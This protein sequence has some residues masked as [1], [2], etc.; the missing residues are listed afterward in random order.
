M[1]IKEQKITIRQLT[2]GYVDNQEAGVKA[3]GGKLD[4]RPP[5]QREFVYNDKEREAVIDTVSNHYPLNVMYWAVRED[6]TYEIIDGQQRTISICQYVNGDFAY[7]FN[8]FG[9]L[10]ADQQSQILDYELCV[11]LCKGTD[12]EKL[13]WFKDHQHCRQTA[14]QPRVAQRGVCL[15]MAVGRQTLFLQIEL[16][17]VPD[18]QQICAGLAYPA[19][20]LG[21]RIALDIRQQD[22]RL[23]GAT[24]YLRHRRGCI[25]VLFSASD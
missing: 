3:F 2:E 12:S 19:R 6:G 1:E 20:L 22:R 18:G 16:R 4:V 24:Q 11:Y 25:V 10:P 7:M 23:Y 9:N 21:D 17:R 15:A 8:Y 13:K 5:Y 14:D